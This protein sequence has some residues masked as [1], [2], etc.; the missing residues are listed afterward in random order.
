ME[1]ANLVEESSTTWGSIDLFHRVVSTLKHIEGEHGTPLPTVI[2][3]G[4]IK[5]HG[6]NCSVAITSEGLVPQSR[7]AILSHTNDLCG[8]AKWVDTRTDFFKQIAVGTTVFGEWC[9]PGVQKGVAISNIPFKIFAIFALKRGETLITDPEEISL[10]LGL[11]PADVS[12]LP[13]QTEEFTIDFNKPD[14]QHLNDKISAIEKEDPFV[15]QNFNVS[16]LGEGLVLYPISAK[17]TGEKV[18]DVN[19]WHMLA[20]KAK[21]EEHR[22]VKTKDAVSVDPAVAASISAFADLVVTP[23]RLDQGLTAVG[24]SKD[25]KLTGK[26]ITW[27]CDDI[28]K[29][30]VGE[31]TA[32]GLTWPQVQGVVSSKARTWFFSN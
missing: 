7:T 14:I 18:C 26:F 5:L 27:L 6:V 31:L 1:T 30:C 9:G 28:Q 19:Q 3:R 15:K 20:F 22:N 16:G 8:F 25:K 21:G 2:Y 29:E 12:V 10:E 13:W 23:A 24:G 11:P 32:S 4:K 17:D